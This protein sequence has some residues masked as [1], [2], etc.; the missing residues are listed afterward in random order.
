MHLAP[1]IVVG[2][3]LVAGVPADMVAI[4]PFRDP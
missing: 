4:S 2:T 3:D 1:E